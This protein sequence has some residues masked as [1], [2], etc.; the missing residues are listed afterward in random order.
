MS[1]I[2]PAHNTE[3]GKWFRDLQ[4]TATLGL[5]PKNQAVGE[6]WFNVWSGDYNYSK[7]QY[8]GALTL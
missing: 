7:A 5:L 3:S 1:E 2:A 8:V 4:E 6:I